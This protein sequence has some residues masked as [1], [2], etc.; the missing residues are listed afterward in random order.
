M[1]A[2]PSAGS[3]ATLGQSYGGL[4]LG[5]L[6]FPRSHT[7]R[8]A[9]GSLYFFNCS[10]KEKMMRAI[11]KI[12]RAAWGW[13]VLVSVRWQRFQGRICGLYFR[14]VTFPVR[15]WRACGC[16]PQF[17]PTIPWWQPF[18]WRWLVISGAF[19]PIHPLAHHPL[20]RPSRRCR[21]PTSDALKDNISS[22]K[23]RRN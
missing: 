9:R 16:P 8:P 18:V 12:Q 4:E 19:G 15:C 7:W 22:P 11:K 6:A 17:R 1:P 21:A 13:Q 2:A 23:A 10:H 14:R 5:L 20:R 3:F